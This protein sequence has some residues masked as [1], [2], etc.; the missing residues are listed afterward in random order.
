MVSPYILACRHPASSGNL[1]S[2]ENAQIVDSTQA[3]C[4]A[5]DSRRQ[6]V[7]SNRTDYADSG[8]PASAMLGA[9]SFLTFV[10][11]FPY[12]IVILLSSGVILATLFSD[13]DPLLRYIRLCSALVMIFGA[14]LRE[15]YE[16]AFTEG[17]FRLL[18]SA[19]PPYGPAHD[20]GK[21]A[22]YAMTS[23]AAGLAISLFLQLYN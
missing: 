9:A 2:D 17:A 16:M 1:I 11:L 20:W 12:S 18:S 21:V 5:S 13:L 4:G 3:Y 8:S 15:W 10:G 6:W 14:V 23:A 7:D 19:P 22:K